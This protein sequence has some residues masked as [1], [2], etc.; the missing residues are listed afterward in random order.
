MPPS[1]V[2]EKSEKQEKTEKAEIPAV[3]ETAKSP[4]QVKQL[5]AAIAHIA[6]T[7][8]EGSIMRLGDE[9][10]KVRIGVIST[11]S[12]AIDIALGI[13]GVPRRRIVEMYGPEM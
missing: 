8:G 9:R 3:T 10:A 4:A 11:G 6:K 13:G 1:K 12:L 5:E 2:S 7:Y